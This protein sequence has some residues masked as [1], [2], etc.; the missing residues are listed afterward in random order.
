MAPK[1]A[2]K[3]GKKKDEKKTQAVLD[4]EDQKLK[5]DLEAGVEVLGVGDRAAQMAVLDKYAKELKEATAMMT[6]VPKPLKFLRPHLPTL[7]EKYDTVSDPQVKVKFA[8]VM[9][10]LCTGQEN[11]V[12]A[13]ELDEAE[14][15]EKEEKKRKEE[16]D[17]ESDAIKAE[18][19]QEAE[20]GKDKP[21]KEEEKPK[22][23][24]KK[25][26]V[27]APPHRP[28][29]SLHYRLTGGVTTSVIEW[30][31]EYIANLVGEIVGEY[32][33][34]TSAEPAQ[35][36]EDLKALVADI[37]PHQMAHNDESACVDLL[38]ELDRVED[39]TA[40]TDEHN[41]ART[42]QY[43]LAVM[44]F[45]ESLEEKTRMLKVAFDIYEKQSK[46]PEML[47]VAMRMNC[48]ERILRSI[49]SCPDEVERKQLGFMCW[50][51]RVDINFEE[52]LDGELQQVT[53]GE[54]L[55]Q[56]YLALAKE[57]DL[58]EPRLPEDIYKSHLDDR[59]ATHLDS[60]KENLAATFVNAFVN[61]GHCADKMLTV[62]GSGWL[63]KNKEE[64]MT[65]AAASLG[66]LL[67]WDVEG[68]LS[69]IDK[70]QWSENEFIK[71][72]SLLAFGLLTTG[73][74]SDCDPV[75]ALLS[76]E[77][78]AESPAL[79]T[80]AV[81]GLG[82][83]YA[84]CAREDLLEAFTPMVI[85]TVLSVETSALAAVSLGLSHVGTANEDA[86]QVILQ[87]LQERQG[88]EG[89]LDSPMAHFFAVGL[90]L[91]FLQKQEACDV[92]LEALD[93]ISH[94]LG[95]Y[96]KATVESC[97]YACSGDV[98]R[99]QSMLQV[100]AE[101]LEDDDKAMHQAVA[102]LG[103]AL[104]A[105]G[106]ECGATMVLRSM[107][108]ILQYGELPLRRAVPLAIGLLHVSDPKVSVV[109]I[110]SKMTHDSDADVALNSIFT[111]GLIGAGTNNAR[112]AGSLR[113]LA[114]F[115]SKDANALF[116]VRIAQGMLFAGKGLV[117]LNPIHSDRF[118]TNPVA[119]GSLVV[120]MH[121]QLHSRDT[122]FAKH[123]FLLYFL[124]GAM[125]PRMLV[126]LDEELN[127]LAVT[128]R[129]G[130]AVD[131]TGQAGKPKS[132]TGFQTHQTPVLLS[133]HER[134]ELG[135]DEYLP[136]TPV[137]EGFVILR[138]NPDWDP[139]MGTA[140]PPSPKKMT[141]QPRAV[142][143]TW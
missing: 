24:P 127:P 136:L 123:A 41:C 43:L 88:V 33:E 34:R 125:Y 49:S 82:F 40:L 117:S 138:K 104:E 67:M 109:E 106:E 137:L 93:T 83:A 7:R 119:L 122:V 80:A 112:I 37:A 108:H 131:T 39:L 1:E 12:L 103:I 64:G 52:E 51:Q 4:E 120:M 99:I 65:S 13:R 71:A 20:K 66:M 92:T 135:D 128:V 30:G 84:G 8:D 17:M 50:R 62:E 31:N 91:L 58:T 46:Y 60:A 111:L 63:Y 45:A 69:E 57:L 139:N 21:K 126:T 118:L 132:I 130:Q 35:P 124:V 59:R 142:P 29:E 61:A 143:S 44:A 113:Q 115:Y 97:A 95:A 11:A 79:K 107:D 28:R 68:N 3:D 96:A 19:L 42:C 22:E 14:R 47:R 116:M 5:D 102:V 6:S 54:L 53:S 114:S 15:K 110:M 2:E 73:V 86:V 85:D 56:H 26:V 133:K 74:K 72:G 134:A 25:D 76:G 10:F 32:N 87:S 94:P 98:L 90:G 141:V 23:E 48:K 70:Y 105:L 9:S 16:A 78:E 101:H 55:S 36:F 38:C 81:C 77:L 89:G 121:A 18:K 27:M 100:C 129:V 75:W 140:K